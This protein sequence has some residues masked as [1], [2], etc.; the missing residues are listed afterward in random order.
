MSVTGSVASGLTPFLAVRV[1]VYV[2]AVPAA[3]VPLIT[4]VAESSCRPTGSVPWT[5]LTVGAG[6]PVRTGA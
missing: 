1:T 2:L 5:R 6:V 4:P 3:G